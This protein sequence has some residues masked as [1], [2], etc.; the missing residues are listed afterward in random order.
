MA[1]FPISKWFICPPG[2]SKRINNRIA[3][4]RAGTAKGMQKRLRIKS[5]K[6]KLRYKISAKNRPAKKLKGRAD[7]DKKKNVLAS[8][9]L[10]P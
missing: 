1:I 2:K 10:K 4:T 3:V 8:A 6:K 9:S 5:R 7:D